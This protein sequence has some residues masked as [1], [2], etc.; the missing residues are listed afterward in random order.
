MNNVDKAL[1]KDRL[2][3]VYRGICVTAICFLLIVLVFT[4]YAWFTYHSDNKGNI[5]KTS[6][7][8]LSLIATDLAIDCP[9][10]KNGV[11]KFPEIPNTLGE[12][13]SNGDGMISIENNEK[14]NKSKR[15]FLE[16]QGESKILNVL[17][18]FK[19]QR[20]LIVANET[21]TP[22]SYMLNFNT[23]AIN[24]DLSTAF[25]FDYAKVQ[26]DIPISEINEN[27]Q[28]RVEMERTVENIGSCIEPIGK[29]R[30]VKIPANTAHAYNVNSGIIST[31]GSAYADA[32]MEMD[33]VLSAVQMD[34]INENR[35]ITVGTGEKMESALTDL[36]GG[37]LLLLSDDIT[38]TKPVIANN[39][40]NL[41]LNGH[42][43]NIEKGG[44]I[45]VQ[46]PSNHATMD[47]GSNLGGHIINAERMKF[48]GCENLSVLNW[49]VDI[50]NKKMPDCINV[51]IA[52]KKVDSES[53]AQSSTNS[54]VSSS[55]SGDVASETTSET[56]S[57]KD[58]FADYI[59]FDD[60]KAA[61]T[62]TFVLGKNYPYITN[63]AE[64][65]LF[66]TSETTGPCVFFFFISK[67]KKFTK[68]KISKRK[69]NI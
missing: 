37:E 4:G 35:L 46:Y 6:N 34:N 67:N 24:K 28:Y 64:F 69:K 23:K 58:E 44:S 21:D 45:T 30:P 57:K 2:G 65:K 9:P 26:G 63:A 42:T 16:Y 27:S 61:K 11:T 39:V 52:T 51:L 1:L 56:S 55:N 62:F 18:N 68:I 33:I 22:M 31:A 10:D 41:D 47:V 8:K 53:S 32:G 60:I 38:I 29:N 5:I 12:I 50:A 48:V 66:C 54:V 17:P 40:F 19:Q 3:R 7:P 13:I 59:D 49:Y 43:L 25:L 14:T 15:K 36:N 20:T